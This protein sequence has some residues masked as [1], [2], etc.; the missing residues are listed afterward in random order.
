MER[1]AGKVEEYIK[2]MKN[3]TRHNIERREREMVGDRY[4][5]AYP[6]TT[7]STNQHSISVVLVNSDT[8]LN[9]MNFIS[10]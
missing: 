7:T 4:L 3:L 2:Q 1:V 8:I 10:K 6:N 5:R 9:N